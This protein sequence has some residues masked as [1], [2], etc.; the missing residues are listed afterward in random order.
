MNSLIKKDRRGSNADSAE[1]RSSRNKILL[2]M[3]ESIKNIPDEESISAHN[4]QSI[5]CIH[6]LYEN[7]L[8]IAFKLFQMSRF[9][10]S[11]K[12]SSK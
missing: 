4:A 9:M 3:K 10:K 7:T 5:S 8:K 12:K 6:N 1:L 11:M 2:F